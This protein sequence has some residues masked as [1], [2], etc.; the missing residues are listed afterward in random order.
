MTEKKSKKT[1]RKPGEPR[2]KPV[3]L[4]P[5][6]FKDALAGLLAVKPEPKQKKKRKQEKEKPDSE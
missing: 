6:D 3:S 5:L 1:R 4:A 2:E